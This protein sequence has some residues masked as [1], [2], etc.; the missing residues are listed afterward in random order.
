[1]IYKYIETGNLYKVVGK[2]LLKDPTTREWLL[3]I[4]YEQYNVPDDK[5]MTFVREESD[6]YKKFEKN[7]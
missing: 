4:I 7:D 1:M 3:S 5:K 6:F 2:A